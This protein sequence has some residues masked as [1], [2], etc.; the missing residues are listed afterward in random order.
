MVK[1]TQ[2]ERHLRILKKFE[3]ELSNYH[4]YFSQPNYSVEY[5]ITKKMFSKNFDVV[6]IFYIQSSSLWS[7]FF[8]APREFKQIIEHYSNYFSIKDFIVLRP[9]KKL[10]IKREQTIS[11]IPIEE[12]IHLEYFGEMSVENFVNV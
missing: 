8:K 2:K 12:R 7:D 11:P 10:I 6:L 1:L 9:F 5:I 4:P 3:K